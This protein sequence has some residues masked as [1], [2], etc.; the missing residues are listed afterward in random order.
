MTTISYVIDPDGDVELVLREPNSHQI[1]PEI[2]S[3]GSS[4]QGDR[5]DS[6]FDNLLATGRYIVFNE[7]YAKPTT[8]TG[9]QNAEE[10]HEPREVRMHISSKHLS[11]VSST[12]RDLLLASANEDASSP[13][14]ASES[15]AR[16]H[17]T[18]WDAVA[19][20]IVLDAIHGRHAEIPRDINLGLLARITTV[21]DHYKCQELASYP[22][23]Y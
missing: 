5:P 12:F 13:S 7:L 10:D 22:D 21:V 14:P 2:H 19:L 23:F 16:V 15:L 18:G 17:T 6:E 8:V 4:A 3:D 9:T 11:F 20:A 1:I